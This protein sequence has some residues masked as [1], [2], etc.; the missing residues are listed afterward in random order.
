MKSIPRAV[1]PLML[2]VLS[3]CTAP[4]NDASPLSDAPAADPCG[5]ETELQQAFNATRD[6]ID[7]MPGALEDLARTIS[8]EGTVEG[9]VVRFSYSANPAEKTLS[10]SHK[11]AGESHKATYAG[12]LYEFDNGT[13]AGHGR[14]ENPAGAFATPHANLAMGNSP[15][16]KALGALDLDLGEFSDYRVT[17]DAA[18]EGQA[19]LE[20]NTT[21]DSQAVLKIETNSSF[22]L[23]EWRSVRPLTATNWRMTFTPAPE[24]DAIDTQL[25]RLPA[26]LE[27]A[28]GEETRR[29]C[30]QGGFCLQATV[31]ETTAHVQLQDLVFEVWRAGQKTGEAAFKDGEYSDAAATFEFYDSNFDGL[32]GPGDL[33]HVD[34]RPNFEARILDR[35]AGGYAAIFAE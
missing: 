24:M 32:W 16:A 7:D 23:L 18:V 29:D 1:L 9:V 30:V 28:P 12:R 31:S 8:F 35:W 33:L 14:D 11:I 27:Y 22:P 26:R 20:R 5:P 34:I 3:G 2:L 6:F 4:P 19:Q 25:P 10:T 17:C 13:F 15:V 21:D